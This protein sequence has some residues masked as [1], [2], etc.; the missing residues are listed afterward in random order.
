MAD[1]NHIHHRLIDIGLSH[2]KTVM[3]IYSYTIFIV[4]LKLFIR[5]DKPSFAFLTFGLI[6]VGL[7]QV[8]F[9]FVK[10][11]N[12][13]KTISDADEYENSSPPGHNII[14]D[15]IDKKENMN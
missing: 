14:S 15:V 9:F 11:K 7:L 3:A 1:R 5:I 13:T 12:K 8:P 10:K 6:A 2:K 4:L